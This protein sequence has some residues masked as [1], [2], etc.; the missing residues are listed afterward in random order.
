MGSHTLPS[1]PRPAAPRAVSDEALPSPG[2]AA[3][4]GTTASPDVAASPGAAPPPHTASPPHAAPPSAQEPPPR[5]TSVAPSAASAPAESAPAKSAPARSAPAG[6]TPAR[7]APRSL[8]L[9]CGGSFLAFLD[10]TI[11][12]LAVPDLARDFEVGVTSVSWVVTL[13]ALPFAALLAPAG[14]LADVFGRR[15]LF[16]VGTAVFTVASVLAVVAPLFWVLLVARAVQGL[17]AALL[18][19]A[20]FAIVLA[21]TPPERRAAAIGLWSASAALAAVAGPALGGILVD[22]AN[23]RVLFVI[24]VPIGAWLL[25]RAPRLPDADRPGTAGSAAAGAARRGPDAVATV[26]LVAGIGGLVLGLTESQRWGWA[27]AA[28]LACLLG[29]AASTAA[30]VG[31][32]ARHPAPALEVDL[33]RIRA[34]ATANV[35]SVLFGAALY[36]SLLLG[37]LFLVEAWDYSVLAA[38][39]AMTPAAGWAALVGIM[40]GRS[41]R[42]PAP[43]AL[44]VGGSVILAATASACALWLPETPHFASGWLPAGFGLGLGIGA[45]SVGVSSAAALAVEPRRFAAAVGLNIAARQVGAALGIAATALLVDRSGGGVGRFLDVYW[46][47]AALCAAAA[48]AGPLLRV[49]PPAAGAA[50]AASLPQPRAAA[51]PEAG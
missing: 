14:R 21:D 50:P 15:R 45:V 24:N 17:G 16:V 34:Y 8:L 9:A 39:F 26:L 19:P 47:M 51:G 13:Y 28:T 37:V 44:V 4:P 6:A 43:W 49:R 23:W 27:S 33:W 30:A 1:D 41:R 18:I 3:S 22:V 29:G 12:N 40:I 20:S 7:S 2:A 5:P 42:Q 32:S 11:T 25:A 36:A 38:G 10:A 48:V 46:L 35:I 31:R